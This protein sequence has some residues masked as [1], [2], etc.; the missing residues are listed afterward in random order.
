MACVISL[1]VYPGILMSPMGEATVLQMC[2]YGLDG[3]GHIVIIRP[4]WTD[5]RDGIVM[6]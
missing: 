1:D 3:P 6:A 5:E 4:M 2:C